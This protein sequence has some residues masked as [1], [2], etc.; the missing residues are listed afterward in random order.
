MDFKTWEYT[1]TDILKGLVDV[2][3]HPNLGYGGTNPKKVIDEINRLQVNKIC[4]MSS[5]LE[6]QVIIEEIYKSCSSKVKPAFG[7]HPWFSHQVC[8]T[9]DQLE[10]DGF[11]LMLEN[12]QDQSMIESHLPKPIDF[13]QFLNELKD[14]LV[15]IPDSMLGEV[16]LDKSFKVH[17]PNATQSQATNQN[18]GINQNQGTDQNQKDEMNLIKSKVKIEHQIKV[19]EAQLE[20]AISL[21]KPISL[22]GVKAI[23]EMI[24]VFNR[25]KRRHPVSN[26]IKIN[27]HSPY[28]STGSLKTL[29]KNYSTFL[30]FSFSIRLYKTEL[31]L[32]RL[33]ELIALTP[34]DKI[35][36]ETDWES[37]PNL[38][39]EKLIEILKVICKVKSW[40]FL[41]ALRQLKSNWDDFSS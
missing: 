26:Q 14:R 11:P 21:G 22:H 12:G 33:N 18:Q 9:A 20:L 29:I 17:I 37:E 5:N 1:E 6:S 8:F 16:G 35:M 10:S 25:L 3:C 23:E 4:V 32:K 28:I 27:W 39:D 34:K 7:L 40:T 2:H 13:N 38:I 19:L 36:I 30:Y 41:E 15:S 31:E 24:Q